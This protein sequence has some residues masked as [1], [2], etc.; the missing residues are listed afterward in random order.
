MSVK[1]VDIVRKIRDEHYK[2]TK[3]L[4]AE[5]QIKFINKKSEELQKSLKGRGHSIVDNTRKAASA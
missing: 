2:V 5:E 1:A 4:S 3:G